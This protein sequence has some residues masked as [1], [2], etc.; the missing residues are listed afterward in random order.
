MTGREQRL[1][2]T[3]AVLLIAGGATVAG[4]KLKQWRES[5]DDREHQIRL[6]GVEAEELVATEDTW[7][8]RAEWLDSQQ[9]VFTNQGDADLELL[10]IVRAAASKQQVSLIQNQLT[11]PAEDAGMK[12]STMLVEGRGGMAEVMRWL[13]DLQRPESFIQVPKMTLLPNEEDTSEVIL[14]LNL[15]KWYRIA[16]D[17]S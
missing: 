16:D 6:R 8:Q 14:N 13:Q 15:Q 17:A 12:A 9:P 10:E 7:K 4:M 2:A 1:A 11:E 3:M 5:V